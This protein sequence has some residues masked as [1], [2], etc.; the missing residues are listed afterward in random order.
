L[1]L[2]DVP[3]ADPEWQA[4]DPPQRRQRTLDAVKHLLLRASQSQPLLV[5]IEDLH[6]L[7]SETQALLDRLVDS[8]STA[9]ILLLVTYRPEYQHGWGSKTSYTQ[10]RLD[11]LPLIS[12]EDFLQALLGDDAGLV[13][14]KRLL[15]ERTGCNPFFLEESVR[16][17]VETGVLVGEAGAYRL[18]Q[19]L[20]TLPVPATMQAVLAA[21]IDRLSPEDK[22]LLQT[23]AVIGTEV[24]LALLQAAAELPEAVLYLGL[25]R[26]QEAE[27][28]Y[29]ANL[30]PEREYTFKHALTH[31]V[32][33]GCLLQERRQA[34]H[35][36]IVAA[37]EVLAGDRVAEAASGAEELPVRSRTRT[38]SSAWRTMPC[39]ARCGTRHR[40]IADRPGRRPWRGRPT[41]KLWNTS[42]RHSAPS[43][44]CQ[45][46]ATHASRP[47]I[48]G[49]PCARHSLRLATL[50]VS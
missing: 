40:Y 8:L 4:L 14:L 33:Y 9:R 21:R 29:E 39:E 18:M 46:S 7:D 47:S 50:G 31:E 24:P 25:A 48:S 43:H 38:R 11:P 5:I 35:A 19:A 13:P 2:L 15:I 12:T 41:A 44:T 17:L 26:L 42:S 20:S 27:F 28:L 23:A 10:L 22:H 34:L 32:A 1:A 49:L 37:L 45:S 36:R 16:T 3:S 30:F 6:W